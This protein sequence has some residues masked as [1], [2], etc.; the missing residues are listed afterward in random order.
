[1]VSWA[2][3][4]ALARCMAAASQPLRSQDISTPCTYSLGP[5][6]ILSADIMSG[7]LEGDVVKGYT[8]GVKL[9]T[10]ASLNQEQNVLVGIQQY[11]QL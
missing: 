4:V 10:L 9:N 3:G 5:S 2:D 8:Q 11:S 7:S 1:M 6:A